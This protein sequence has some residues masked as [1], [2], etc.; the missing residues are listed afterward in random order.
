MGKSGRPPTLNSPALGTE[1]LV[2]SG[3]RGQRECQLASGKVDTASAALPA[4][5]HTGAVLPSSTAK[6]L[7]E[8]AVVVVPLTPA[9][10]SYQT[11]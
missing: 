9:L 4:S 5:T 3:R 2:F 8:I 10:A 7:G 1:C 11:N 6:E